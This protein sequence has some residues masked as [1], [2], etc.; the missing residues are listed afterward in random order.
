MSD[1][2]LK[3]SDI[4]GIGEST[5]KQ[6]RAT[7]IKSV[8]AVAALSIEQLSALPGFGPQRAAAVSQSAIDLLGGAPSA[9]AEGEALA[10]LD[11]G[12]DRDGQESTPGAD[13]K[14]K[15]L[16]R[17]K[18]KRA[19]KGRKKENSKKSGKNKKVKKGKKGKKGKKD[20]KGRKDRKNGE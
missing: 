15:Q 14:P 8:A 17:E 18:A 7:G 19:D 2:G 11:I 12:L 4:R 1:G 3:L 6:L 10:H 9:A 16:A 13:G 20:K 5:G